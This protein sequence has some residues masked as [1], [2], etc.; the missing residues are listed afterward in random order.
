LL[1]IRPR[2]AVKVALAPP[3][4]LYLLFQAGGSSV[5]FAEPGRY[6]VLVELS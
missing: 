2:D 3:A 5:E 4:A 6:E 1:F